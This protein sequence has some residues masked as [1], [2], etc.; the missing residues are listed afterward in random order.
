MDSEKSILEGISVSTD[1]LRQTMAADILEGF[2]NVCELYSVVLDINGHPLLEPVGPSPYLGEFY[3]TVSNPKYF[4]VYNDI[5]K[6]IADSRQSMYFEL[7]DGNPD[8]RM[9]ASPIFIMGRFYATWILYAHNKSQNQKLFKAFDKQTVVAAAVSEMITKIYQSPRVSDTEEVIKDQLEFEKKG[10]AIIDSMLDIVVRGGKLSTH[11]INDEVGKL[12]NVDYMVYYAVDSERPGYMSLVGYWAK[13]GNSEESE[14]GFSWDYDHFDLDMQ[15]K[16]REDGLIIDK[17]TMTNQM[18]VEVF[19]GK[20]K[21]IMIFPVVI[22]GEYK[23]RIIFIDNTKERIWSNQEVSFARSVTDA[24]SRDISIKKRM[25][26]LKDMSDAVKGL[27]QDMPVMFMVRDNKNGRIIY[28]NE[29]IKKKTGSSLIGEN[30]FD[31]IPRLRDELSEFSSPESYSEV[32]RFTRYIE[33]LQGIYEVREVI[34]DW[35]DDKQYSYLAILPEDT[36]REEM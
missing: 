27:F 6:C 33:Q 2:A 23:G 11:S 25:S 18:R 1:F 20:V 26:R 22:E 30:G 36:N 9:S 5:V 34:M 24:I 3:E 4:P 15:A 8:S 32:V 21:A 14:K 17:S 28:A 29:K 13:D 12:L 35:E 31:I 7:D 19:D 10:K 16:I